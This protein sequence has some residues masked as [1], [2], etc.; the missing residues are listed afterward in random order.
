MRSVDGS[1]YSSHIGQALLRE[2][3]ETHNL[4][5][6]DKYLIGRILG[7]PLDLHAD[8]AARRHRN[9]SVLRQQLRICEKVGRVFIVE[10]ARRN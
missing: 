2:L 9:S 8:M 6:T 1:R 5:P 7:L 10:N 4:S 3:L